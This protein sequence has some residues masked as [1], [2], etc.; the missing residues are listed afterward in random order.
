[1]DAQL[2][3]DYFSANLLSSK[4]ADLSVA[5]LFHS[6]NIPRH[7]FFIVADTRVNMPASGR[8]QRGSDQGAGQWASK[9]VDRVFFF[10][11]FLNY[12]SFSASVAI[13]PSLP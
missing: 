12:C 10:I 13:V 9:G 6:A 1:M 3:Q 7:Y 8:C 11:A 4:A 5:C 2:M